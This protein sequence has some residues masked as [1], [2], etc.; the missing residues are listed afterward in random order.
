MLEVQNGNDP[1]PVEGAYVSSTGRPHT[2]EEAIAE[3]GGKPK[4]AS[5]APQVEQPKVDDT[6]V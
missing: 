4:P 3:A 6:K 1:K 5:D 2:I